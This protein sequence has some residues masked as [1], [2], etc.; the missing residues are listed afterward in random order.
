M[1]RSYEWR[2][3]VGVAWGRRC[4]NKVGVTV[5]RHSS[6]FLRRSGAAAAHKYAQTPKHAIILFSRPSAPYCLPFGDGQSRS[7]SHLSRAARARANSRRKV[8]RHMQ[9]AECA[10]RHHAT[11]VPPPRR[12]HHYAKNTHPPVPESRAIHVMVAQPPVISVRHGMSIPSAPWRYVH[13][14][15]FCCCYASAWRW[16]TFESN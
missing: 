11:T 4:A 15:P 1:N 6:S 2:E 12:H 13:S 9:H 5:V 8:R 7:P 10:I 14:S 3:R 16:K